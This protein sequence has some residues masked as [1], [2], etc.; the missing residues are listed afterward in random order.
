MGGGDCD[1]SIPLGGSTAAVDDVVVDCE[2]DGGS[3]GSF[4]SLM[5][6]DL[7]RRAEAA[8]ELW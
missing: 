2:E 1:E 7:C 3:S 5:L 4:A 6:L 8:D